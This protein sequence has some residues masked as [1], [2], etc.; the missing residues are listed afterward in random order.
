MCSLREV[1]HSDA[2][3]AHHLWVLV[4]PIV[5]ATLSEKKEQQV[6]L[7]HP[8]HF[9]VC[10]VSLAFWA[11]PCLLQHSTITANTACCSLNDC[12]PRQGVAKATD[13]PTAWLFGSLVVLRVWPL[14]CPAGAARLLVPSKTD[15][16]Q[17]C[18][19]IVCSCPHHTSVLCLPALCCSPA[20]VVA[21]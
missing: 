16:C 7:Q 17:F 6:R 5:W 14:M 21:F 12:S 13:V 15:S 18:R 4:F 19:L 20:A 2:Y 9:L 11:H 10:N 8:A 1:A 3:L